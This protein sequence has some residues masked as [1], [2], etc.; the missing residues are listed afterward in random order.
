MR[1]CESC[2]KWL[3]KDSGNVLSGE[4]MKG[5]DGQPQ[6]RPE[7]VPTPCGIC[8]KRSPEQAHQFELS[9]KNLKS[10]FLY[11]EVQGTA[12]ACL[13]AMAGDSLLRR[14]M[15]IIHHAVQSS[16]RRD[17]LTAMTMAHTAANAGG[18]R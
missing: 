8:P 10:V 5:R 6:P 11:F 12:G 15:G 16:D 14:N 17:L 9:E 3:Y 18:V 7:G 1:T 13:G 2:Q 4:K